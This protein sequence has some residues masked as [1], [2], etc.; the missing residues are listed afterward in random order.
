MSRTPCQNT[1]SGFGRG[2]SIG[3][4]SRGSR[5]ARISMMRCQKAGTLRS[6]PL[7]LTWVEMRMMVVWTLRAARRTAVI[8]GNAHTETYLDRGSLSWEY[9]CRTDI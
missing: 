7:D 5:Q 8:A 9:S 3:V 6:M 4:G 1:L 2:K